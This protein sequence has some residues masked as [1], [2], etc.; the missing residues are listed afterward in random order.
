MTR[1]FL[2]TE[3][4]EYPNSIDLI[5]LGIKC[6]DGR[7]FYAE[8]TCFD[9]RKADQW[10]IDN[11]IFRLRWYGNINSRKGFCNSATLNA[12][13][14]Q[15]TTEIFGTLDI[16]RDGVIDFIGDDTPEFWGYYCDYDWVVVCWLFGKMIKL[17]KNWPMFCYDLRQ[18]LNHKGLQNVTQPNEMPHNALSDANWIYETYKIYS[19]FKKGS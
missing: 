8:S 18:W 12:G 2:D 19:D 10:V 13:T 15:E 1:Y 11:V 5:S 17:P 16:I 9:E 7:T 4:I 14:S 6:E 3:F